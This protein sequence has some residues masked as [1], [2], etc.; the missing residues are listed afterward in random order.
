MNA[1]FDWRWWLIRQ[2][3][4]YLDKAIAD[5]K[6]EFDSKHVY[7][8]IVLKNKIKPHGKKVRFLQ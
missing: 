3:W 1:S 2:I 5:T 8:K 7:N 4:Y 6:K